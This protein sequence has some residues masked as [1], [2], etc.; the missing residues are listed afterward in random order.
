MPPSFPPRPPLLVHAIPWSQCER[1]VS[2]LTSSRTH[3]RGRWL[4]KSAAAHGRP[5]V[6]FDEAYSADLA[7]GQGVIQSVGDSV[8]EEPGHAQGGG[9]ERGAVPAL[10][11]SSEGSRPNVARSTSWTKAPCPPLLD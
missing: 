4:H 11:S 6:G 5:D 1:I 2:S 9:S 10:L 3:R 7:A 8:A